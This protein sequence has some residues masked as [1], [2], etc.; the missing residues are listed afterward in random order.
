MNKSSESMGIHKPLYFISRGIFIVAINKAFL[1]KSIDDIDVRSIGNKE[2][3]SIYRESM[4]VLVR[5]KLCP[6][7]DGGV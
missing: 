3:K 1:Y 7:Y 6:L 4:S 2:S 5:T